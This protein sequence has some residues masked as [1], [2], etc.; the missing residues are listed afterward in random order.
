[1][2]RNYIAVLFLDQYNITQAL[3]VIA[4]LGEPA[5][6]NEFGSVLIKEFEEKGNF[7][8]EIV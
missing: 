7:F 2:A 1:M 8:L 3:N 4:T 6:A 5:F